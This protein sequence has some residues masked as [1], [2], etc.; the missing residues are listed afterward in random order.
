MLIE[1]K[2]ML[3][4]LKKG[5]LELIRPKDVEA[6]LVE[7]TFN[8][9]SYTIQSTPGYKEVKQLCEDGPKEEY[10]HGGSR[11]LTTTLFFDSYSDKTLS[12]LP[13]PNDPKSSFTLTA[14]LSPMA[15]SPLS[16]GVENTLE[17]V[18]KK[19]SIIEQALHLAGEYHEPAMVTLHWGD[20]HFKGHITAFSAEYTMFSMQG[21]PIRAKVNLTITEQLDPKKTVLS[22]PFE[23]PDRTKSK[24]IME[25]MSLWSIAYDEYG[26][27]EKWRVIAKANH[28]MDPKE[29]TPGM[30][31]AIP[32]IPT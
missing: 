25:G 23:S 7:F 28:I 29:L 6:Q 9:S 16:A 27:C 31:I 26:D 32:A 2:D 11:A 13:D 15:L 12:S 17:P 5:Y 18:S 4:V 1:E 24:V 30:I 10:L 3:S 21:K 20:L 8:P 22:S 14:G 19:V